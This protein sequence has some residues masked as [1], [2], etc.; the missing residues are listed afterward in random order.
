MRC[1]S[2]KATSREV[3][4]MDARWRHTLCPSGYP[5]VSPTK[6]LKTIGWNFGIWGVHWKLA[7]WFNSG[8]YR[9]FTCGPNSYLDLTTSSETNLGT[10]NCRLHSIKYRP[11]YG[12]QILTETFSIC[13]FNE[14]QRQML[15]ACCSDAYNAISFAIYFT[16]NKWIK[17]LKFCP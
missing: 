1:L 4:E 13:T 9:S 6:L 14:A 8:S 16:C 2:W 17:H 12:L 10:K 7:C 5:C 11:H 15:P 3:H